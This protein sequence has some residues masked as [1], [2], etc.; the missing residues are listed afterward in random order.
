MKTTTNLKMLLPEGKD[1]V[2]IG[3]LTGNFETLD[4]YL[5]DVQKATSD[6]SKMPVIFSQAADRQ[7]I[8]STEMLSTIMGKIARFF[9]DIKAAAFCAIA[10]ND[11]TT[12]EGYVADARIV[13]THGDEIDALKT[14]TNN[15]VSSLE[16]AISENKSSISSLNSNLANF[17]HGVDALYNQ[18]VSLGVTPSGKTLDAVKNSISTVKNNSYNT[19]YANGKTEGYNSGYSAGKAAGK[20]VIDLGSATSFNVQ[21]VCSSNGIDPGSL[22]ADNF[23]CEPA[24]AKMESSITGVNASG[25]GYV[26]ARADTTFQKSYSSPVLTASYISFGI[27]YGD[28]VNTVQQSNT[29]NAHAYLVV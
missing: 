11:N 23:I 6:A 10:N 20:K 4:T 18:I 3:D 13:K 22:T 27:H 8:A 25:G 12:A 29:Y 5:A 2:N 28:K 24:T 15:S 21:A 7:N 26:Y 9:S 14:S 1:P 17:Q 16:K 19:G